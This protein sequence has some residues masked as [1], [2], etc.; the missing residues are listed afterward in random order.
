[1][2]KILLIL[3]NGFSFGFL[4]F[5]KMVEMKKENGKWKRKKN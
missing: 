1:M 3:L 2:K 5:G 4:Y